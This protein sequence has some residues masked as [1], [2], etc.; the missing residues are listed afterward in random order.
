MQSASR[1]LRDAIPGII[2]CGRS[3]EHTTGPFL[4][5]ST[6][7]RA[8]QTDFN[9]SLTGCNST[10]PYDVLYDILS[11]AAD[12][13]AVSDADFFPDRHA[14]DHLART[15]AAAARVCRTWTAP[16]RVLLYRTVHR[17]RDRPPRMEHAHAVVPAPRA[18]DGASRARSP[19]A[20][21]E[22]TLAIPRGPET[23]AEADA[24]ALVDCILHARER[25]RA[26]ERVALVPRMLTRRV[27]AACAE[28][29][30]EKFVQ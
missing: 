24:V 6:P 5:Q 18:H 16:A 12:T 29:G 21:R 30:V 8:Q 9:S 7:H 22:L 4:A 15:L 3:Y 23:F 14:V 13:R 10:L 11:L 1:T 19:R 28:A 26:L 20:L 25:G 17:A 27:A 2:R